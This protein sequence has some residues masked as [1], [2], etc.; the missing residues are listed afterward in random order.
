VCVPSE[1]VFGS[2]DEGGLTPLDLTWEELTY[3]RTEVKVYEHS[4]AKP[5]PRSTFRLR[6][7]SLFAS[8]NLICVNHGKRVLE[9]ISIQAIKRKI[10]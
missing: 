6:Y 10:E 8:S 1:G 7:I 3:S 9:H 2:N 5:S 4:G